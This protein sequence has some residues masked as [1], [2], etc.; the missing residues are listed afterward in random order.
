MFSLIAD[1]EVF[2]DVEGYEGRYSVSNYGRVYSYKKLTG[3]NKFLKSTPDHSGYLYIG[4][5][6]NKTNKT[7]KIHVLVG[8]AFIGKREGEMS[9]DHIDRNRQN[10]KAS[11]LRLATRSQQAINS[12][13]Q[14]NNQLGEK[15]ICISRNYYNI[16]IRR[17]KKIVFNRCLPMDKFS[18]EDAVK[19]RDDF[20]NSFDLI[21]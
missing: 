19:I 12:N 17:N 2:V 15:N 10:N 14:S 5:C 6:K 16:R 11:N 9:F 8:N 7:F 13:I 20:I 18:L 3:G 4:L 21:N 1:D